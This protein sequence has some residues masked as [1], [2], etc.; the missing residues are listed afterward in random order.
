MKLQ[1]TSI[2]STQTHEL[3]AHYVERT[4]GRLSWKILEPRHVAELHIEA[5]ASPQPT[6][7][8]GSEEGND[9]VPVS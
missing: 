6:A 5:H 1:A 2:H 8:R 4:S 9:C 3:Y 7:R